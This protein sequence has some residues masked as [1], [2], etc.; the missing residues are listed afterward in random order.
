MSGGDPPIIVQGGSVHLKFDHSV[1]VDDGTGQH[2][3]EDKVIK[4]VEI[5]G[6]DISNYFDSPTGT[7]VT[8]KITYGDP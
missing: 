3:H 2:S 4:S 7:N 1:L 6:A 8:V 5:S